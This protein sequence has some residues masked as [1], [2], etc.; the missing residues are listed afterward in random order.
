VNLEQVH[1]AFQM[2]QIYCG[3]SVRNP[4]SNPTADS[5]DYHSSHR[6]IQLWAEATHH[7]CSA[8]TV[9]VGSFDP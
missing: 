4:G 9:L 2:S 5:C 7:Y 3:C 6:H 1:N 8:L